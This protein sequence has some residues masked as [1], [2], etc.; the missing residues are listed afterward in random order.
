MFST[1][2]SRSF[3]N[4]SE[5]ID[6]KT[7]HNNVKK[8]QIETCGE[9]YK[10]W[11]K[12]KRIYRNAPENGLKLIVEYADSGDKQRPTVLCIHGS[13][14]SCQVFASLINYLSAKNFRVIAPNLPDYSL[15]EKFNFFRHTSDEKTEFLKDFLKAIDVNEIDLVVSHS[16]G[17]Y[18]AVRLW[19]DQTTIKVKALALLNPAG[20]RRIRGMRPASFVDLSVHI[21]LNPI[22]RWIYRKIAHKLMPLAGVIVKSTPDNALLAATTMYHADIQKLAYYLNEIKE[23][24]IPCLYVFSNNDKLIE[25]FI[26][27]EMAELLGLKESEF[28]EFG[29]NGNMVQKAISNSNVIVLRF[30]SAGHYAFIKY[31]HIVN[32]WIEALLHSI[33]NGKQTFNK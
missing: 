13:P 26:F 31:A 18:P 1:V 8:I 24:Q 2:S 21:Y 16:S 25:E 27:L 17:V 5:P 14:G 12:T 32:E 11:K 29:E 30:N 28:N 20:H 15:T 22:G 7:Y 4:I 10:K 19:H 23:K 9:L 33:C 6:S 3:T